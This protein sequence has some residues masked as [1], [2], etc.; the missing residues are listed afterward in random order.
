MVKT[1][2]E[3]YPV[4]T[5]QCQTSPAPELRDLGVQAEGIEQGTTGHKS[6]DGEPRVIIPPRRPNHTTPAPDAYHPVPRQPT[7]PPSTLI[8][9]IKDAKVGF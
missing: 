5:F 4:P 8:Q 3:S 1:F 6:M 9:K 7:P 2:G